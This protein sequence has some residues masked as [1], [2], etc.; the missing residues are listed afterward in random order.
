MILNRKEMAIV[1]DYYD[2]LTQIRNHTPIYC[3]QCPSVPA[4]DEVMDILRDCMDLN[5]TCLH[6]PDAECPH[7]PL[8]ERETNNA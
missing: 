3:A 8:E 7:V 4:P 1:R 2:H 5:G 6:D